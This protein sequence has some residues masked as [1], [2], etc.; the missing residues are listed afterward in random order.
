[1]PSADNYATA[2]SNVKDLFIDAVRLRMV[3]DVPVGAFLSGGIDSSLIVA[4]MAEQTESPV[5]TFT[6]SFAE[7][8]YD[9]SVYAQQMA[10][11]YKT[12]HHRILINP[13]EFLFSIDD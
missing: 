7:K 11:L 8:E 1:M 2:K 5:N 6:V 10:S 4:C 13:E 12:N 3:S 9:E